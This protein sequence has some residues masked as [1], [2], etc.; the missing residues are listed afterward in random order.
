[1]KTNHLIKFTALMMVCCMLFGCK[2][3]NEM[4]KLGTIYGTVTDFSSGEPI[5]N[6][7][8]RL[9][10]RGET[11]LTGSDGTFQF[12]DLQAGSYS[13][14][15]SK[16]GYVDLDDDYVIEIENGNSVKRDV[17]LQKELSSLKIV[18]NDGNPVSE[19]DFG[20]EEG[21]TQKTFSIFNDGNISLDYTITKTSDW[22]VEVV[23]STGTVSIGDTK[24]VYVI[25]NRER[26]ADGENHSNLLITTPNAGGVELVVKATKPVLP[27]VV[28]EEIT[29]V[30]QNSAKC[31]GNVSS[32]GG[33]TVTQ[34]GVCYS[35]SSNPTINDYYVSGG[36]GTGSFT[37]SLTG[38]DENTTYYVRTYATN[39]VGTAYG[40][41][42]S[43]MTN[44]APTVTTGTV[45]NITG[46]TATCSGIVTDDGGSSVTSR[47]ICWSTA[48]SP[49]INSIL[50][51]NG[52]GLGSY[53]CEMTDLQNNTT[54]YVRAFAENSNGVSYGEERI[55]TTDLLPTFE[56]GGYTY[57][58]APDV[59]SRFNWSEVDDYCNNLMYYGLSGWRLPT[60]DELV[61]MYTE[62]EIIG[63][64]ECNYFYYGDD[65]HYW[66]ST[67]QG[68][69][70]YSDGIQDTYY[71]VRFLLEKLIF[72]A[73]IRQLVFVQ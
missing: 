68:Q 39:S 62:R 41:Q 63:G 12:N 50:V 70:H 36:T 6:A 59:G 71:T 19:L 54:Y 43:F 72:L 56:H 52:S 3:E 22:I 67:Y 25:I 66:S 37:C 40:V 45:C 1:M 38:L 57:Y 18:D 23:P 49:T 35:I 21:M 46:R 61:K 2:P 32:D 13:L 28:T 34:K 48:P 14:S 30:T 65:S 10:P 8:V 60:K 69:F 15:L 58:V 16:N 17:H 5:N 31:S 24:P 27:I 44:G 55:F 11:T 42:K 53:S 4:E 7:N 33:M 47:G 64:F 73:L 26:L 20:I 29:E 51:T 9:N